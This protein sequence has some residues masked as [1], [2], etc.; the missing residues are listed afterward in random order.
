MDRPSGSVLITVGPLE[1][2]ARFETNA[3][4]RTC[5]AFAR[6]L[7]FQGEL[8]QARWSGEAAWV[9][10]G[11]LDL[12][13]SSE[14]ATAT[15]SPGQILFYPKGISETEIL[16]PYGQTHFASKSGELRGNHFLT[17]T[18]G[19]DRLSEVGRVVVREGVQVIRILRSR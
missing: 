13:I 19:L 10:L 8:L 7:P 16:F 1:F 15:P 5:A 3:A 17:L 9:P 14:N 4:P 11:D 2:S 12:G 18:S 6:V